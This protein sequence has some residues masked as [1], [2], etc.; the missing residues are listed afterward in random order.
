MACSGNMSR[1]TLWERFFSFGLPL[2][3]QVLYYGSFHALH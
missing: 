2:L 3:A 1:R